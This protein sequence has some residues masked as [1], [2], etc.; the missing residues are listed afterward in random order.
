[1]L[2]ACEAGFSFFFSPAIIFDLPL[3]V[4]NGGV[5]ALGYQLLHA[6]IQFHPSSSTDLRMLLTWLGLGP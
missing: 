4:L 6:A 5:L 2:V 1:V 3:V